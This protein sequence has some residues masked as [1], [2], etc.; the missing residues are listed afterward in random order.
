MNNTAPSASIA[1]INPAPKDFSE[2]AGTMPD[3][4]LAIH[5]G[6]GRKVVFRWR[7][8]TGA[9]QTATPVV[10]P[11][12]D[13]FKS[14]AAR[15]SNRE[16]AHHYQCGVKTVARWRKETGLNNPFTAFRVAPL[17]ATTVPSIQGGDAGDAAQWLRPTHRPV[18]HRIIDGKQFKGQYVVGRRVMSETE[19]L[20]YARSRGWRPYAA[21]LA[22]L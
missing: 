21:I 10:R 6:V 8:L 9:L 12:P 4:K 16:L 13:D 17:P 3:T 11:V 1:H 7:K 5:Y 22:S 20:E 18:Y 15:M 19:L 2:V 14:T